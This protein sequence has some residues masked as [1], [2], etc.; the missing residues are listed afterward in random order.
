MKGRFIP[1]DLESYPLHLKTVSKLGSGDVIFVGLTSPMKTKP[2]QSYVRI[3]LTLPP[4][5]EMGDCNDD[6]SI[7][8]TVQAP[9]M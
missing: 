1:Y 6:Q 8:I 2:Y 9:E 4:R 7:E 3:L 5:L